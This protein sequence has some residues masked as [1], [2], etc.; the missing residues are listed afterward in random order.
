M[1]RLLSFAVF[2][3]TW[4]IASLLAGDA[5]LPPPPTVLAAMLAE[6]KSG[7]LFLNLGVTLARVALAFTLAMSLGSAI[8]Y[9]MGRVRLADRLGDPWLILLLNLPALVV[10][11]L[12]Y[13]WAGLTEI[14]AIAAIAINKLPTAV[15]T[16]REG[17]RALDAAL[18][19]M[20]TVFALPRS[21]TFRHVILPQ[22]APYIAAAARSGL[23][24]V[25]KIVL[26]AELLGRPNGVGFEIGV[27]F[28][29][30]DIPLLLAYSLSFAAVVLVIETVLVQP[31]E[32]RLSRWRPRAA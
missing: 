31:F 25:W 22:L 5:K 12:A 30:F 9:L 16:L 3:A 8:G 26:V 4:W 7:D 17:A 28:Q 14:A 10:I 21:R 11:V 32:A 18:D 1:P 2:F 6:A 24:L 15:V 20:A 13:I 19:E 29:L 23:S 27:A